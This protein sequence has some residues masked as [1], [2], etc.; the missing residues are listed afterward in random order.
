[1]ISPAKHQAILG[2]PS[3]FDF[4][5]FT[6]AVAKEDLLRTPL[7]HTPWINQTVN[8]PGDWALTITYYLSLVPRPRR[9][10]EKAAWYLLHAHARST[11][12]KPGAPNTTVYFP[13]FPPVYVSKLLRVIQMIYAIASESTDWCFLRAHRRPYKVVAVVEACRGSWINFGGSFAQFSRCQQ[14][15]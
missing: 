7:Y 8:F 5:L 11:P 14:N 6:V 9:G 4:L 15:S 2:V 12:T 10:G 1:M 3:I 13:H